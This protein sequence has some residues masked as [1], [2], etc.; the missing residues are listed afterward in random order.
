VLAVPRE[1]DIGALRQA[2]RHL[3][4]LSHPDKCSHPRAEEAFIRIKTSFDVLCADI[5][6]TTQHNAA[7]EKAAAEKAAAE[8]AAAQRAAAQRAA[9]R[10]AAAQRAAEEEAAAER[11]FGL[12]FG[13]ALD[14]M[15]DDMFQNFERDLDRI[16]DF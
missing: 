6:G 16:F 12:L 4:L 5:E 13:Q 3:S 1:A 10:R 9:A 11:A 8:R 14:N 15:F 7:A 2:Y